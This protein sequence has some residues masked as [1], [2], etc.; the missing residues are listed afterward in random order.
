MLLS[1][2]RYT[3]IALR[4]GLHARCLQMN[5]HLAQVWH[6]PET[7][8][9]FV[10]R[11]FV[12]NCS[13]TWQTSR[14]KGTDSSAVQQLMISLGWNEKKRIYIYVCSVMDLDALWR[15]ISAKAE[16]RSKPGRVLLSWLLYLR[17]FWVLSLSKHWRSSSDGF[18]CLINFEVFVAAW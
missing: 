1:H 18:H 5:E 7:A 3:C 17:Q 10:L 12:S 14:F 15:F 9:T 11:L 2:L 8:Q 4:E 13:L 6:H 16:R